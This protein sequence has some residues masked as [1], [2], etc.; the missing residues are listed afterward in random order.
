MLAKEEKPSFRFLTTPSVCAYPD[1]FVVYPWHLSEVI[2][3]VPRLDPPYVE[4]A[5]Y[6]AEYRN[7]HWEF[8]MDHKGSAKIILS[9]INAPYPKKTDNISD[10]A[11]EDRGGNF[12]RIARTGLLNNFTARAG[13]RL[14]AG[15]PVR[16]W[17]SFL[18]IFTES[19]SE[20]EISRGLLGLEKKL[21]KPLLNR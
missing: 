21:T 17:R 1:L 5:R 9:S 13:D 10:K 12:G 4:L 19:A 2:S 20:T 11:K 7:Y 3:G 14:L 16:H 8:R 18:K 6:V 15:I